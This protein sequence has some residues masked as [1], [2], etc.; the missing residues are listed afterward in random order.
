MAGPNDTLG[1]PWPPL[2]IR[3]WMAAYRLLGNQ[4]DGN[5]TNKKIVSKQDFKVKNAAEFGFGEALVTI[6]N[7]FTNFDLKT[8]RH[9]F[10]SRHSESIV[11]GMGVWHGVSMDSLK[12]CQGL[13]CP[14]LLHPVSGHS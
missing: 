10:V 6:S 13:P 3:P 11:A 12:Y 2:A 14:T 4:N 1:S 5:R 9:F 7:Y 8:S